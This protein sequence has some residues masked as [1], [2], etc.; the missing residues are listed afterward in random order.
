MPKTRPPP[1]GWHPPACPQA[2]RKTPFTQGAPQPDH[3]GPALAPITARYYGTQGCPEMGH[4]ITTTT[5]KRDLRREATFYRPLATRHHAP[6]G[7]PAI[8]RDLRSS[9]TLQLIMNQL[10]SASRTENHPDLVAGLVAGSS[11]K[12]PDFDR[13]GAATPAPLPTHPPAD[14]EARHGPHAHTVPPFLPRST[15]AIPAR[16]CFIVLRLGTSEVG[17]L[18]A[19]A[20]CRP[21]CRATACR[22]RAGAGHDHSQVSRPHAPAGSPWDVPFQNTPAHDTTR[23]RG[24]RLM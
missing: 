17:T 18:N 16:L 14:L 20:K 11:A 6:A 13:H 10:I 22:P 1:P 9:I 12:P 15:I 19:Q 4:P 5:R 3:H 23:T 8:R 7:A 24:H 2:E 21:W